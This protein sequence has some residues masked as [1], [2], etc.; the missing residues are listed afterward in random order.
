MSS[1]QQSGDEP[2]SAEDL[3]RELH[4]ST[5]CAFDRLED[6]HLQHV[7]SREAGDRSHPEPVYIYTPYLRS[8][9]D[10]VEQHALLDYLEKRRQR[11]FE[12]LARSLSD[13]DDMPSDWLAQ[14]P[15]W[16]QAVDALDFSEPA[17]LVRLLSRLLEIDAD[18]YSQ[19]QAWD[20]AILRY[21]ATLLSGRV[22]IH[23]SNM[24]FIAEA[25]ELRNDAQMTV[26]IEAARGDRE[27]EEEELTRGDIS[28]IILSKL[29]KAMSAAQLG[30]S[31]R[32]FAE[33]TGKPPAVI[34]NHYT[35]AL[36][37]S[38][39]SY[40]LL[41]KTLVELAPTEDRDW[42]EENIGG[43]ERR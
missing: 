33:L 8:L 30:V 9:A 29:W 7:G 2:R 14:Q 28:G 26:T 4:E 17:Q 18:A 35:R 11:V 19:Y 38:N 12:S 5:S 1:E 10:P 24:K 27:P 22:M 42:L 16:A 34:N 3:F 23:L 37:R 39:E 20:M 43:L 13:P 32:A 15:A 25:E 31:S 6:F 41:L 40:R 36:T 21:R